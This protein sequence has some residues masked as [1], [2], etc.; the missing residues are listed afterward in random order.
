M[1][2]A[3]LYWVQHEGWLKLL[4]P[5]A[6]CMP[7]FLCAE[8]GLGQAFSTVEDVPGTQLTAKMP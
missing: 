5:L 6:W 8:P 3:L 7:L 1:D 2:I 4:F